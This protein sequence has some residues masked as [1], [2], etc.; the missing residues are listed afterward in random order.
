MLATWRTRSARFPEKVAPFRI[1]RTR[2]CS[3]ES[4]LCMA[5]GGTALLGLTKSEGLQSH[6]RP[7]VRD[8]GAFRV[9][10]AGSVGKGTQRYREVEVACQQRGDEG[11]Y[12]DG[13]QMARRK[14]ARGF[15]LP[16][17]EAQLARP[18]RPSR[19]SAAHKC[20]RAGDRDD[21][22]DTS[23]R[24]NRRNAE[25]AADQTTFD[26]GR[27]VPDPVGRK[28]QQGREGQERQGE[29]ARHAVAIT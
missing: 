29:V 12:K 9:R 23:K 13:V 2:A 20:A 5:R 18:A 19:V 4:A 22:L 16:P 21:S 11:K 25:T 6:I 24:R 15:V 27:V 7:H 8:Q 14:R 26:R 10:G 17:L 3:H 1:S 28:R